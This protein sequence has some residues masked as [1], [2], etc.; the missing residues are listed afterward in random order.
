MKD[1]IS[2]KFW[3][4]FYKIRYATSITKKQTQQEISFLKEFL[5]LSSY[6]TILDFMCGSGRHILKLAQLGYQVTG[7]DIDNESINNIKKQIVKLNLE[8]IKVYV[9]NAIDFRVIQKFDAAICIYSAIGT[10]D[11]KQNFKI[12]KNFLNSVK[13]GGRLI[14][15]LP[16]PEHLKHFLKPRFIRHRTYKGREYIIDHQRC[17]EPK[18]SRERNNIL[19]IDKENNRKYQ[20]EYLLRLYSKGEVARI[21][22]QYNFRINKIFGSFKKE[23]FDINKPRMIIVADKLIK[24]RIF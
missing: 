14:W 4:R 13:Y 15:D 5:P 17:I 9:K 23:V 6:T 22:K 12:I 1:N 20:V 7:F 8:N 10:Q 2:L 3:R 21:L 24:G 18:P 11:E 19:I 16:N